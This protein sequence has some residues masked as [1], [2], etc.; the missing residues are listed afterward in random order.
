MNGFVPAYHRLLGTGELERRVQE[1]RMRLA[2][3]DLCPRACRA[4]RIGGE[5]GPCGVGADILLASA[6]PHYGEEAELTGFR[7]SGTVFLGGCNLRCVFCQNYDISWNR[8][9][10]PVSARQLGDILLEIQ[11]RGCHNI[12]FVSPSHC[13]PQMLEAVLSA[14]ERGLCLPLVYN[15]SGYDSLQA[16]RLLDGVVDIYM[17]DLKYA[18]NEAGQRL[19]GV[20]DYWD[21]AREAL[22]EMH[23]QVGDLVTDENLIARRGLLVRHLVLPDDLA[24]S[25]TIF[26][27]LAG[28]SRDTFVNVMDQY[29]PC[30]RALE[31]EGLDRRITPA[32]HQAAIEAARRAGLHRG[33]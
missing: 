29:H 23:R 15:S 2:L 28:L 18:S 11:Q 4:N 5:P 24:D 17:P 27:F 20:P 26:T 14:A 6:G 19:S 8:D 13:V 10:T 30:Y 9:A 31:F 7:G 22:Q 3:C 33:F 1:A 32:E 16:L 25:R 12:N 21:R